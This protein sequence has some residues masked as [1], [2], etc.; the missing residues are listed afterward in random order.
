[1]R[2][3]KTNLRKIILTRSAAGRLQ[4]VIAAANRVLGG[5]EPTPTQL[6]EQLQRIADEPD[7]IEP[8]LRQLL[9]SK[10]SIAVNLPALL[11]QTYGASDALPIVSLGTHCF[12]SSFLSRWQ[13]KRWSG[14]F[15]WLFSSMPMVAHCLSDNFQTL[16]DPAFYTPVPMDQRRHGSMVNRVQH[17]YYRKEYHIEFVFNHHDVHLFD[18]HAY[19][20]RCTAR[21]R[22]LLDAIEPKVFMVATSYAPHSM[23]EAHSLASALRLRTRGARL[24]VF[25]V[26]PSQPGSMLLE[27]LHREED[28][29]VYG[30]VPNSTLGPTAFAELLDEHAMARAVLRVC[31]IC[32]DP[33]VK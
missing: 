9:V 20:V 19:L 5:I 29:E 11:A 23:S 7:S 21:M 3:F 16:L 17:E 25:L 31:Q 33:K 8:M 2:D 12:T 4:L 27:S 28:F 18:D 14:P 30:F 32:A 13:L 26:K 24:L 22:N 6:A 10:S 1:M 15:D